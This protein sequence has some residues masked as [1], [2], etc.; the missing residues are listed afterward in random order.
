MSQQKEKRVICGLVYVSDFR[1]A[2]PI[3]ARTKSAH[4]FVVTRTYSVFLYPSFTQLGTRL[5]MNRLTTSV[6][7]N[8]CDGDKASES[9]TYVH[10]CKHNLF[11]YS[12]RW[13]NCC[14][15]YAYLTYAFSISESSMRFYYSSDKS[16]GKGKN[17]VFLFL[18]KGRK[19]K[20]LARGLG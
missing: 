6:Y 15:I 20:P 10:T 4:V 17:A 8:R 12:E 16:W 19:R 14:F 7:L 5:K 18:F 2:S 1:P 9:S 13:R 3:L 11:G